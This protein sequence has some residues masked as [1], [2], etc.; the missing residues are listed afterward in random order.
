MLDGALGNLTT[1]GPLTHSR[2]EEWYRYLTSL[3]IQNYS[4]FYEMEG[5]KIQKD[6]KYWRKKNKD[7]FLSLVQHVRSLFKKKK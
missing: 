7:W 2:D 5:E 4:F 3:P 6:G 1:G